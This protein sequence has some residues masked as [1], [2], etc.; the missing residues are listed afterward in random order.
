MPVLVL[1]TCVLVAALRSR[2]GASNALLHL[3]G[4]GRFDTALATPLLLEYE[5]VLL[6]SPDVLGVT[7]ADVADLLDY[8]CRVG[9]PADV[10]FRVRPSVP[11]PGDEMVLEAAVASGAAWIVTHNVRDLAAGGARFGVEVVTPGEALRRLGVSR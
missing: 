4:T 2:S 5:A 11:D 7:A 6:R 3:V 10:H 9:V 1:D 8:L